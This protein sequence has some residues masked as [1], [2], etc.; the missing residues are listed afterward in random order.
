MR[1]CGLYLA[2]IFSYKDLV[3]DSALIRKNTG[4]IKPVLWHFTQYQ[5]AERVENKIRF[6]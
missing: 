2:C 6:V 5:F 1:E 4:Q 3:E